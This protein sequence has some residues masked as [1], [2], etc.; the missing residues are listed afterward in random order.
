MSASILI[1]RY[2][3]VGATFPTYIKRLKSVQNRA[4]RVVVKCHYQDK[5]NPYYIQFKILQID[6]PIKYE[7]AKFVHCYITNKTLNS[8]CYD[9]CKTV[10]HSSR[11]TRQ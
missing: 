8:L 6:D 7:I 1:L 10:E 11:V 2:Y 3:D 9:F 5:V 4:I